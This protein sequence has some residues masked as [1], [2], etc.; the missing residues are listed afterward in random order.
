MKK[1]LI[2]G[3]LAG[4]AVQGQLNT[5]AQPGAAEATPAG[6]SGKAEKAAKSEKAEKA[7]KKNQRYVPFHGKVDVLDK[8]AGTVKVGERTFHITPE[9]KITKAGKAATF[10]EATVGEE[11]GGAFQ[12]VES[13]RLEL[14]S[15]RIGPKPPKDGNHDKEEKHDEPKP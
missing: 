12:Q 9:T 4:I 1:L 15:L 7:E 6:A 5:H 14:T 2:L 8:A 3:L 11:V 13:G 10:Q